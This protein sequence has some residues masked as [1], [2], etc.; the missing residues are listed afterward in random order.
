MTTEP[1]ILTPEEIA[2]YRQQLFNIPDALST[3]DIIEATG[4]DLTEAFNNYIAPEYGFGDKSTPNFLDELAHK[5][6]N[7]ICD[8][9][10]IDDLM[11]GILTGAVTT[12]TATGQIPQAIATPIVIYLAKKG[13]KK[14]CD[15]H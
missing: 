8:E 11:T 12:L 6:R 14:W 13:V 3:L 2:E 9:T 5:S 4:G 10:F 1:I 15:S 7:I